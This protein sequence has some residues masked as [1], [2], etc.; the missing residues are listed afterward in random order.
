MTVVINVSPYSNV[1]DIGLLKTHARLAMYI[2]ILAVNRLIAL[3]IVVS[4]YLL[5]L[6]YLSLPV[7]SSVNPSPTTTYP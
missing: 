4:K 1:L 2:R 5:L 7:L 3:Y 6:S